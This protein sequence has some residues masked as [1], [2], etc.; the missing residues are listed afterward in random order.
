[1]KILSVKNLWEKCHDKTFLRDIKFSCP[2]C[3]ISL[4]HSLG[5]KQKSN[6]MWTRHFGTRPSN[7]YNIRPH[8]WS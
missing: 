6:P 3:E 8:Q 4:P 5:T 1:M 2:L 7:F